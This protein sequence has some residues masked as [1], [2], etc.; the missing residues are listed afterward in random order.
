MT[1]SSAPASLTL[2]PRGRC[3]VCGSVE[4]EVVFEEFG[5]DMLEC[6][7]CGHVYSAWPGGQDYDGY[8]G[9]A[10]IDPAGQQYWNE[11]HARMYDDFTARFLTGRQGR[12]LD[13]GCG[14]GYFV[15]RVA[16]V[17]GWEAYGYEI[18]P[19][20][21]AFARDELGL[22]TVFC[23]RVEASELAPRSFDIITLWDVIEHIPDPDPLLSY[24]CSLLTDDGLLCMHTPNAIIQVPKAKLTR[25]LRGMKPELHYLEARDHVN[26][27]KMSTMR[28]VLTRTGFGR[29]EFIHLSP[30]EGVAGS[31][32]VLA[33]LAKRAWY[34]VAVAVFRATLG[35][36]NFDNLFVVARR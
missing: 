20:A 29:V 36:V 35:R 23:G 14:L 6:V 19:Q 5:V 16:V 25:R 32:R 10:P 11:Q 2:P 3:V 21:A 34:V 24:L 17:P 30:I 27:Y 7:R 9:T 22:T 31:R 13:V 12:L 1:A 33:R 18:S 4:R 15:Q 28:R 26:L 8:F